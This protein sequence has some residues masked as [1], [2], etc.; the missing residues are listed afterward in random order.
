[1]PNLT[2]AFFVIAGATQ[3]LTIRRTSAALR[4]IPA[5]VAFAYFAA[6]PLVLAGATQALA[7]TT[8][9]ELYVLYNVFENAG[10]ADTSANGCGHGAWDA[11]KT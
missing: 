7:I 10:V 1:L 2:A 11:R 4:A 9:P 3:A 6:L 5:T 8:A